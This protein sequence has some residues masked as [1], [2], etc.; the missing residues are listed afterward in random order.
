M[1]ENVIIYL[2]TLLAFT[3]QT[4]KNNADHMLSKEVEPYA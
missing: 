4:V 3:D 1:L 2:A